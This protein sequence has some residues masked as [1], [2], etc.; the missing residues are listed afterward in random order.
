[1]RDEELGGSNQKVPDNKK[2]IASLD[3]TGMTLVEI[4]YREEGEPFKTIF[5]H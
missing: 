1:M 2:A 4:T 3:L 5:R